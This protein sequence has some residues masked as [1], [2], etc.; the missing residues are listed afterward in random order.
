[1]EINDELLRRAKRQAADSGETLRAVIEAALRRYLGG[2]P[3]RDEYRLSWR[4]E[5]GRLQPGVRLDD[6]DSLL[7]HMEGRS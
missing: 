1:M 6:R 4:T 3:R 5:E 7:D 2:R